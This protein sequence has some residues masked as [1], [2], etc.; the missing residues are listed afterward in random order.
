MTLCRR[1]ADRR[2]AGLSHE[3]PRKVARS[4][5]ARSKEET[6]TVVGLLH[7]GDMGAAMGGQLTRIGH[8]VLWYSVG[9]SETT[10]ARAEAAA[11]E[12]ENDL[13][14]ILAQVEAVISVCPPMAAED[15]ARD[16]AGWSYSGVWVEANAI[17]PRRVSRIAAILPES[18]IVDGG[19]VGSP[20]TMG[21][22]CT[23]YLSGPARS[24]R[25]IAD[26]FTGTRVDTHYLGGQIGKAS[27]LKLSYSAYQKASR[28]LAAVSYGLAVAH[29]VE[30]E[31]LG[32][33]EKRSGSYLTEVDYIPKTAM[34]A[35]RW[36]PELLEAAD[37]LADAG[38]PD[39]MLRAPEAILTR[40]GSSP[41]GQD[42]HAPN[43][44]DALR[45]LRISGT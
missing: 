10:R 11:L 16:S 35:W 44:E 41:P 39:G 13:A 18:I 33:A 43:V 8:R 7:P 32:I 23:L 17:T 28:V 29:G 37:M 19:I 20:P 36:G 2:V 25:M 1:R 22:K 15:V 6:V 24:A 40:L 27:G 9:R 31:L 45:R 21:K 3:N 5:K 34:R 26:L 4:S 30:K 12:E 38:L 14:R 42:A